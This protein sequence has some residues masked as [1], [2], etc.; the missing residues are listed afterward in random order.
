MQGVVHCIAVDHICVNDNNK[1]IEKWIIYVILYV[2]RHI[3]WVTNHTYGWVHMCGSWLKTWII[4]VILYVR[5]SHMWFTTLFIV[6]LGIWTSLE[7][8]TTHMDWSICVVRDSLYMLWYWV[9]EQV[10]SHEPHIWTH[11][12]VWFV[13]DSICY[14]IGYLNKSWVTNH[15]YGLIHMCGSWL[16]LYVMILASCPF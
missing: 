9:S 13:T 16:T 5:R 8:R 6:I 10:L 1:T 3:E 15:T 12:Y 11:P 14:D 4:Y 2:R 7:S